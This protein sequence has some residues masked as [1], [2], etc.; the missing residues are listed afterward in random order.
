MAQVTLYNPRTG[1]PVTF[2]ERSA[3]LYL[4]RGW[5]DRPAPAPAEEHEPETET[6]TELTGS[7]LTAHEEE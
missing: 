3:R 2:P 5:R 7:P 1:S 6:G 4:A